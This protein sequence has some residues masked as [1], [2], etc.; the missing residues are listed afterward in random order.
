MIVRVIAR[1][2][3]ARALAS[4]LFCY[5]YLVSVHNYLI[6]PF[7]ACLVLM[8]STPAALQVAVFRTQLSL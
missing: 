6:C 1:S 8:H 7:S 5:G 4:V 3:Y 2:K